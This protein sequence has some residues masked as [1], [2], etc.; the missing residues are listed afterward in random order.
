MTI[1]VTVKRGLLAEG[2]P[3]MAATILQAACKTFLSSAKLN[4]FF[5]FTFTEFPF[6]PR[7]TLMDTEHFSAKL[8]HS[9]EFHLSM[10]KCLFVG[11][12]PRLSLNGN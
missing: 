4:L 6:S 7:P 2:A 5:S 3:L 12:L 11:Q 8:K 10:I 9:P 1:L